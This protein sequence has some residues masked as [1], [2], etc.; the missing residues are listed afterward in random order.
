MLNDYCSGARRSFETSKR[1]AGP[2]PKRIVTRQDP[3]L[4]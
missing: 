4:L 2:F 1:F 3:L